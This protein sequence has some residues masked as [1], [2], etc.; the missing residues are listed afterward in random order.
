MNALPAW[1]TFIWD[2][3]LQALTWGSDLGGFW[4]LL[5]YLLATVAAFGAAVVAPIVLLIKLVIIALVLSVKLAM[6]AILFWAAAHASQ[7]IG[8]QQTEEIRPSAATKTM[9]SDT[10]HIVEAKL[11]GLHCIHEFNFLCAKAG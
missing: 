5:I 8:N 11:A 3:Y 9:S 6:L 7:A 2:L 10:S 4:G 1:W